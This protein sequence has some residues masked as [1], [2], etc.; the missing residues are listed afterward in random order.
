MMQETSEKSKAM[1]KISFTRINSRLSC[2]FTVLQFLGVFG[3]PRVWLLTS[4]SLH[5][6]MLVLG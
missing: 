2:I 4:S 1:R 3:D 5:N 6:K